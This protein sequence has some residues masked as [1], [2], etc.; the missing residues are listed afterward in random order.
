M[1]QR[2]DYSLFFVLGA[3]LF[4]SW[5]Y[6]PIYDLGISDKEIFKYCGWAVTRGQVPYRD[7]FD[8]KP[9]LIFFIY[10]AGLACGG[11]WGLW[12]LNALVAMIT[13][14]ALFSCARRYKLPFPW[15]LPLLFNLMLRDFLINEGNNMTR[16]YT[17]FFYVL[18]FCTLLPGVPGGA[19]GRS[20]AGVTLR[21]GRRIRDI[22]P[23]L[24]CGLVFFTQQDQ[25]LA[26]LP[27]IVDS[28]LSEDRSTWLKRLVLLG[29]GFLVVALPIFLYFAIHGS[30]AALWDQ[31]FLFNLKVY[32][33]GK[34]SLGDHFRTIKRVMDDGNY[35]IPFMVAVCLGGLSLAGKSRNKGLTLAAFAGV[36][37]TLSPEFMGGRFKGEEKAIDYV[38]YFLPLAASVPVLLFTVMAFS[39]ELIP[40]RRAAYFVYA[41]LLCCSL[42][43]TA[44]QHATHLDRRDQDPVIASPEMNYLRAHRPGDYQLY[45][46]QNEDYIAAYYEFRIPAPSR[47][48]YQ[49]FWAWYTDWDVNGGQ[50]RSIGDDLLKHHTTY[51]IMDSA[52]PYHFRTPANRDWWLSFMH[53]H[54]E[55]VPLPGRAQNES[56]LWQLKVGGSAKAL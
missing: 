51:V 32:A 30:L 38:Y 35:E 1:N 15:L 7:F 27:F 39:E 10:A 46:F 37:L 8:H 56:M 20:G 3:C 2:P 42:G 33:T 6:C 29:C 11:T 26:L 14:A 53:A 55:Q 24:L 18:F 45:V 5:L 9:P 36:W 4:L 49:H 13:S 52:A 25:V 23:G 44:L 40:R 34:K 50:L 41:A 54:Y 21:A 28:F 19:G 17:A 47:W 16:E 43:Y 48:I 12:T 22:L 31:A